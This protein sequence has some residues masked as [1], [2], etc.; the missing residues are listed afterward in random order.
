M[1]TPINTAKFA[2]P[3]S[4]PALKN[5]LRAIVLNGYQAGL[6]SRLNLWENILTVVNNRCG[7]W[8]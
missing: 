6:P 8:Y 7:R 3:R 5:Y 1:A 4:Q 2:Q